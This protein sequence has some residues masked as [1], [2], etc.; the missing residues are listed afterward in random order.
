MTLRLRSLAPRRSRTCREAF[1]TS[2]A[3]CLHQSSGRGDSVAP[4]CHKACRAWAARCRRRMMTRAFFHFPRADRSQSPFPDR[5]QARLCATF[6]YAPNRVRSDGSLLGS[7]RKGCALA[8][9][10]LFTLAARCKRTPPPPAIDERAACASACAALTSAGCERDGLRRDDHTRCVDEC[11]RRTSE[12]D[13]RAVT[14]HSPRAFHLCCACS[15][16]V[17]ETRVLGSSVSGTRNRP[18]DMPQRALA[19]AKMHRAVPEPWLNANRRAQRARSVGRAASAGRGGTRGLRGVSGSRPAGAPENSAC[20]SASVCSQVC[21]RC[22]NGAARYLARACVDG[23]C[24]PAQTACT[25]VRG[26]VT[27]DPCTH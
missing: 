11:T 24:A 14:P 27:P 25:L 3:T 2:S 13:R 4:N 26:A 1:R 23:S 15:A 5:F 18:R 9:L 7:S 6:R 12:L 21:C 8:L 16:R 19:V 20:Q 10:A 17:S 22:P